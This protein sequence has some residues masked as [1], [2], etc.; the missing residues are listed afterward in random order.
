MAYA[1]K[2]TLPTMVVWVGNNERLVLV[3]MEH[4]LDWAHKW[5]YKADA[6]ERADYW[7]RKFAAHAAEKRDATI[8][9]THKVEVVRV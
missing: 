9:T 4:S 3:E 2:I 8:L 5:H 7:R 6:E 1:I